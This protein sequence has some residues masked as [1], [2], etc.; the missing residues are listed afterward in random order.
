[1]EG[2]GKENSG[3]AERKGNKKILARHGTH[4][5]NPSTRDTE[6]R[7]LELTA[8]PGHI[9]RPWLKKEKEKLPVGRKK[10][11]LQL[12]HCCLLGF[13]LWWGLFYFK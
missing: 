9:L 4:V 7:D 13:L 1:M 12:K 2:R 10:F 5:Y 11:N 6:A 3:K 8:S